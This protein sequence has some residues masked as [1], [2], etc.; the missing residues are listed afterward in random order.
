M[1]HGGRIARPW[2]G[3]VVCALRR[4]GL[5]RKRSDRRS[6]PGCAFRRGR[7]A[8]RCLCPRHARCRH[9]RH[10]QTFPRPR[11]GRGRLAFGTAGGSARAC[12]S[13]RRH[14]PVPAPDRQWAC[15][16][17]GG[18]CRLPG[19]RLA[20]GEFFKDLDHA[21]PAR[22]AALSRRGV[23]RRSFHGRGIERGRC[24]DA[25]APGPCRRLRHAAGVQR[26][27]GRAPARCAPAWQQARQ[28]LARVMSPPPLELQ[29]GSA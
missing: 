10:R 26:P 27:C 2:G 3:P 23:H 16:S 5:W 22:R 28:H 7:A 13:A 25:R 24:C 4:S 17:H 14:C 9:G 6:R 11:R 20:A 18:A 21:D 19:H 8:R 15:G 12:G 1:A 29:S